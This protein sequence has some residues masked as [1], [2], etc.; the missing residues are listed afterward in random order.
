MFGCLSVIFLGYTGPQERLNLQ[1]IHRLAL[2]HKGRFPE[3]KNDLLRC[4]LEYRLLW[5]LQPVDLPSFYKN[6]DFK[7][8]YLTISDKDSRRILFPVPEQYELSEAMSINI[9]KGAVSYQMAL[10]NF[11]ANGMWRNFIQDP[12]VVIEDDNEEGDIQCNNDLNDEGMENGDNIIE[13]DDNSVVNLTQ[14]SNFKKRVSD[15]N[16]LQAKMVVCS[17]ANFARILDLNVVDNPEKE[18]TCGQLVDPMEGDPVG[19]FNK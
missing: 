1:E 15:I 5:K 11:F 4:R 17:L 18:P 9:D 7:M 16:D 3:L 6:I 14:I 8:K 13:E 19:F 2:F 12:D 10:H